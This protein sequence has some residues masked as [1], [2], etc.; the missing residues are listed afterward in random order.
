VTTINVNA[1]ESSTSTLT[2]GE[3]GNS[4]VA[5]DS[6][7]VNLIK[8]A[9]G[10]TMWQSNGSGVLSNVNAGFGDSL[11]LI[12]TQTASS[13]ASLSFTSGID[14]TYK[15]YIWK[16][17]NIQPASDGT[18]FAFQ[19]STD[20]GSS[21]GMTIQSSNYV[22]TRGESATGRIEY[23]TAGDLANSTS[24]QPLGLYVGSD[25]DECMSGELHIFSPSDTTYV[26]SFYGTFN[27]YTSSIYTRNPYVAGYINDA[28]NN[29]DAINFKMAS[30][31]IAAGKI[32]MYGVK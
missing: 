32:K 21:Y 29:V 9:S 10:A 18:N 11:V 19:V 25:T 23:V 31:N 6:V 7:N 14:S 20:G 16:F 5:A 13:S 22:A 2:I 12:S 15:E 27:N 1:I 17:I 30:G 3:S 26:K 28:A 4:V 24:Y 8:D